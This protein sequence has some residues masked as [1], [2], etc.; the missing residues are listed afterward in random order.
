METKALTNN[1]EAARIIYRAFKEKNLTLLL[2]YLHNDLYCFGPNDEKCHGKY[3]YIH[4]LGLTMSENRKRGLY[5]DVDL[6]AK[7]DNKDIEYVRV[8]LPEKWDQIY[9]AKVQDGLIKQIDILRIE[10]PTP[11]KEDHSD[12]SDFEPMTWGVT[13]GSYTADDIEGFKKVF[14]DY[15]SKENPYNRGFNGNRFRKDTGKLQLH[16]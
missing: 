5:F 8:R 16:C 10:N 15:F 1:N 11:P 12:D 13:D 14:L 6:V 9:E 2:G 7:D 4:K 3:N